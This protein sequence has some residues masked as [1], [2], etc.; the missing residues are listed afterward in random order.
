[1][2]EDL[3][4]GEE[5]EELVVVELELVE[6]VDEEKQNRNPKDPNLPAKSEGSALDALAP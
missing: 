3:G 6:I 2:Q 1:M 5:E 4:F